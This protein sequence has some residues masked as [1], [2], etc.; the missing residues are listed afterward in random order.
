MFER[1]PL[2]TRPKLMP[3]NLH[4]VTATGES[5]PF[6]GKAKIEIMLGTQKLLHDVLIADVKNDGILGMDF[7]TKHR[8]DVSEQKLYASKWP[9]DCLFSQC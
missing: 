4:L 6:L 9:Q 8:C 2:E 3:V 5:S 1:W 7:L